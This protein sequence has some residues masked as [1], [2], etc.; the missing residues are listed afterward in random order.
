MDLPKDWSRLL[1]LRNERGIMEGRWMGREF[2]ASISLWTME[3]I[4][5]KGEGS[6]RQ[7]GKEA[8]GG[9]LDKAS[10][11]HKLMAGHGDGGRDI[12]GVG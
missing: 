8:S 7:V 1:F 2:I 3:I 9:L 5:F 11:E 12:F 10:T 6:K 4:F